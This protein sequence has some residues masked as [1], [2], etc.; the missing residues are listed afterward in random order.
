MGHRVALITGGARGI[1]RGIAL[2]LAASGWAIASC[3]LNRD[4]VA[5]ATA[6]ELRA[7]GAPTLMLR[8]DVSD[9]EACA[10]LVRRTEAELGPIDALV[11]CAGPY[12]RRSLLEESLEGWHEMFDGNLHPAIYLTRL[13]APGMQ[14]RGWGRVLVFSMARADRM[15]AQ[16]MLTAH[17]IAK[18]GLLVLMRTFAKLLGAD[19]VTVNAISP[20]YIDSGSSPAEDLE[21]A[22]ASIPAGY[23]GSVDDVVSAARYLLSDEAR[24]VNG[25]NLEVSGGWGA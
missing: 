25:A 13:V 20:G 4:D 24:Y 18:A 12:H 16:P 23:I 3:Y 2:D 6:V 11:H 1:G 19:G 22:L 15:V 9:A 17:Y 14:E 10:D 7:L 8:C 5:E 21:Q